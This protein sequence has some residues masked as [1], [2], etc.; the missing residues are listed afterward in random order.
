MEL[1][2]ATP[3]PDV[4]THTEW[5][6]VVNFAADPWGRTQLY[7]VDGEKGITATFPHQMFNG[8]LHPF[9]PCRNGHLC[10]ASS[11]QLLST[12]RNALPEEPDT[13]LPR[14]LW[15]V[16]RAQQWLTLAAQDALVQCGD[17][18]E[19]PDFTV[20]VADSEAVLVYHEDESSLSMWQSQSQNSGI[21]KLTRW[22]NGMHLLRS[23]LDTQGRQLLYAPSWGTE[24][25]QQVAGM[26]A[27]WLRLPELPVIHKWQVPTTVDELREAFT[28]QGIVLDD[29]LM[30]L[31]KHVPESGE[32]LLLIGAPIPSHVGGPIQR[33]HWQALHLLPALGKGG[34]LK[35]KLRAVLAQRHLQVSH[36]LRWLS[37]AEN[38]HPNE[39]QSRGRLATSLRDAR[40]LLL[41]AGAVGGALA[42]QLV[43]MGLQHLTIVDGDILEAGNLVRHNLSM[44]ELLQPKAQALAK[45]L[46]QS[47][48]SA[49]VTGLVVKAPANEDDAFARAVKEATLIIDATADDTL[50]KSMPLTGTSSTAIFA[51]CS[52][53][54][55][56]EHLFFYADRADQFEW[57][58][59]STWFM[60]YRQ[61]QDQQ[62]RQLDLPRGVGCWHPLTPARLNRVVGLVGIAV[63]LL[64]QMCG[65]HYTFPVA[66]RVAWPG[67]PVMQ[68]FTTGHVPE[69]SLCE[70]SLTAFAT[71]DPSI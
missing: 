46:N 18:Y 16:E 29:L 30:P 57:Q 61:E 70:A 49:R 17:P 56:A 43:R 3:T 27:F 41:G 34:R 47:T 21:A 31:W 9:L 59:F 39:L 40:V 37:R 12:N 63:E 66:Q 10:T 2:N 7:P 51:S 44:V 67:L 13:T 8:G 71:M 19:L 55:H 6:L 54:L 58:Q 38:W 33:Y 5:E 20:G 25:D 23:F 52:V 14:L 50:L 48:P 4:P 24:I 22:K 35:P 26:T 11:F 60:P 15:H 36:P 64:E 53:S 28:K 45:G 42:E 65:A 69:E 32:T 62:A 68:S 1:R